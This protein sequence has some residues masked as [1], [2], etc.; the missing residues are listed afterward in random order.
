MVELIDDGLNF[1]F[2]E[3]HP[4]ARLRIE[5][6]RTLRIPDDGQVHYLP[7]GLGAFPL[8]HVDDVV[9]SVSA[10]WVAHG[11]V[12]LP[13][14]QSEA[15]WIHLAGTWVDRH[16]TEYPFAVKIA[17]GK[18]DA[19]TGQTWTN[20]LST[21]PQNY[22]VV[23][24]Q[25]WLDGFCVEK[26]VIRQFVAMPLSGGY[27]AEEQVT[28]TAEYGGLQI[29]VHP[30][31]RD[32]FERRFPERPDVVHEEASGD[33]A[34]SA[35]ASPDMGL[36]P[37]GRMRQEIYEDPF[38]LGEW[39]GTASSRCY[40]HMANSLVWEAITGEPPPLPPPTAKTY[41]DHDLPWF[42]Y[43]AEGRHA[44]DGA[45]ALTRLKSVL[46][47]GQ[48]NGDTPLPE[49]APVTPDRVIR[50]RGRPSKRQVREGAV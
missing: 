19:V 45:E 34:C 11:G 38:G 33:F 27:T 49:N 30:L 41:T 14:Y 2:P 39:D 18:I 13:M 9:A 3:V 4:Q 6:Q 23:P 24:E 37:G 40:V 22:L 20:D 12:L 15:L 29:L 46:E 36:A 35:P 5:F 32:V 42:D 1:S 48:H 43:Y 31:R 21:H 44:L 7:P 47:M 8:T 25:P 28:G 10:S 16:D 26:G 17:A 50:Y